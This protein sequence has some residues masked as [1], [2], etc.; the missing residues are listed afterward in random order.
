MGKTQCQY[1]YLMSCQ[2]CLLPS[3]EVAS[4]VCGLQLKPVR[5]KE[6]VVVAGAFRIIFEWEFL[7]P[8]LHLRRFTKQGPCDHVTIGEVVGFDRSALRY[9]VLMSEKQTLRIKLENVLL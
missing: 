4:H 8:P 1:M 9:E 3:P 5:L 6:E 7:P 2:G